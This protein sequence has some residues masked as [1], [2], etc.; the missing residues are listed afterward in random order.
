MSPIEL[1]PKHLGICA[2]PGHGLVALVRRGVR[3]FFSDTR[4]AAAIEFAFIAPLLIT[5][6]LGTMEISQGIEVNKKVGRSASLIGDL[7]AQHDSLGKAQIE[8]IINIGAAVLQ[9]YDRDA[10]TITVTGV[11]IDAALTAKVAWSRKGVGA[12]YSQG[13]AVG[14]T[15]TIPANLKIADTFLIKV[16]TKLAYLPITSWTIHK[17][18]TGPGGAY[19]SVDM[20]EV[21]YLRPRIDDSVDCLDC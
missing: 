20:S 2:K 15:L 16:E 1:L 14:S 21:Y 8:D 4:G 10:P 7:I 6:Y 9:P 5:L 13:S 3:R 19:A 18:N 17:N 12:T 11:N